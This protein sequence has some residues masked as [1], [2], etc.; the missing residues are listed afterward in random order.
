MKNNRTRQRNKDSSLSRDARVQRQLNNVV[1]QDLVIHRKLAVASTY[2]SDG[3][4]VMASLA[5]HS[6]NIQGSAT[7]YSAMA[8]VWGE[9]RCKSMRVTLFPVYSVNTT[10][11]ILPPPVIGS[12]SYVGAEVYSSYSALVD[13]MNSRN[14]GPYKPIVATTDASANPNAK[15]WTQVTTGAIETDRRIGVQFRGTGLLAATPSTTF[16]IVIV[17]WLVQWRMS[18]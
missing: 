12:A 2:A 18:A 3:S 9:Y 7:G 14:H 15:L 10:A 6:G 17:E 16:F 11:P 8:S 5:W 1:D 4:G 13:G